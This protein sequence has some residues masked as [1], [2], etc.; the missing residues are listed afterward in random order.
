MHLVAEP[1]VVLPVLGYGLERN[2]VVAVGVPGP[3]APTTHTREH[4]N[5]GERLR[6]EAFSIISNYFQLFSEKVQLII[7]SWYFVSCFRLNES[8]SG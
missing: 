2:L 4:L 5:N 6:A 8:I 7:N 3:G 1:R